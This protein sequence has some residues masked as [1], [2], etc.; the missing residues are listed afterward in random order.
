L[1]VTSACSA[2]NPS[3]FSSLTSPTVKAS[4]VWKCSKKDSA[5]GVNGFR[6]SA[7]LHGSTNVTGFLKTISEKP[8]PS[9]LAISAKS[10]S[11]RVW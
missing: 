2:R 7:V 1:P 11:V 8:P 4:F 6:S 10:L 9:G 3:I 5:V